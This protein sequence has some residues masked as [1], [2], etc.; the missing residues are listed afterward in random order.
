[1]KKL[2]KESLTFLQA[3]EENN[4]RVWFADQKPVFDRVFG[5]VKDFFRSIYEEMEMHDD[6]APIHIHRIYRDVRF[7][8]NKLPYKNY[9]GL[10]IAR[11]K[12]KLRGGYYLNIEP[13]GH[14]FVGGGFWEPDAADL[15]RIRKDIARDPSE[16]RAI[17][18]HPDFVSE[19]GVLS[20]DKLKTAP[21]GF[22]KE[23]EAIDLL[24]HKQFLAM[25]FYTDEEILKPDFAKQVIRGFLALQ[26]FF[27][28]M[29]DVLT[30][31]ANGAAIE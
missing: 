22:D 14:S 23:H 24:R 31:D 4:N 27:D 30:T 29:T 26:P 7:S 10:H 6:L 28:Y 25:K 18:A 11:S 17:L 3:L 19:F 13:G 16:L 21:K 8:K 20:G 9:F 15:L 1:M 12:P 5:D 2:N